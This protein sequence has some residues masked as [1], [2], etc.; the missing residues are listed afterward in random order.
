MENNFSQTGGS[1]VAYSTVT[2]PIMTSTNFPQGRNSPIQQYID[3]FALGE[4]GTPRCA[5]GKSEYHR[6]VATS[7][8]YNTVYPRVLLG[9]N[10]NN[11]DNLSSA[12]LPGISAAELTLANS[13]FVNDVGLLGSISQGFNHTSPTSGYVP[14]VPEQYTPIQQNQAFYA[15]DSWKIKRNLTLQY[16]VRWEYQRPYDAR[17][18]LVLLPPNNL[19]SLFGPTNSSGVSSGQPI[20]AGQPKW[21]NRHDS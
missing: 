14:N 9:T 21:R 17:K 11:P 12:T 5:C 4:A 15:Q 2:S 3:N 16:G 18:R 19:T 1:Q 13:V 10:A 7:Y 6:N 8:V 20:P